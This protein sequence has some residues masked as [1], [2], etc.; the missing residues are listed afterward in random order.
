MNTVRSL[1]KSAKVYAWFSGAACFVI[2][3][4]GPEHRGGKPDVVSKIYAVAKET[5]RD[6]A[7][8]AAEVCVH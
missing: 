6:V 2:W 5:G 1:T 3:P 7:E 8:V 4:F